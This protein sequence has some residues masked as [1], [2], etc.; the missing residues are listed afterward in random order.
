MNATF[1][2]ASLECLNPPIRGSIEILGKIQ[3]SVNDLSQSPYKG[4]NRN[5]LAT[6]IANG[7]SLNPPIRGSIDIY[8]I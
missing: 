5:K 6:L 1:D 3:V 4:F 8:R 7:D 2:G